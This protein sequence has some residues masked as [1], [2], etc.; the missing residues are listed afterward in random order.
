MTV[1]PTTTNT[2]QQ[3]QQH[4]QA[5]Q[6]H[7]C[8]ASLQPLLQPRAD[9]HLPHLQALRLAGAC[10]FSLGQPAQAAQ[11]F[12]QVTQRS[13]A[14]KGDAQDWL[15]L[16]SALDESKQWPEAEVAYQEALAR[17]PHLTQARLQVCALLRMLG[18]QEEAQ[19]E[20]QKALSALP[21]GAPATERALL[22]HALGVVAHALGGYAAA[23]PWM[24]QAL[25]LNPNLY[26][27][28]YHLAMSAL[29]HGDNVAGWQGFEWR[30]GLSQAHKSWR[31]FG[32]GPSAVAELAAQTW[33]TC[34]SAT[35]ATATPCASPALAPLWRGQA[36]GEASL[37]VWEE[38]GLGDTLQFFRYMA[39]LRAREPKATL[40]FW[41]RATLHPVLAAWAQQQGVKL[42]PAESLK[43]E[44]VRGQEW[45]VPLLSLPFCLRER[46]YPPVADTLQAPQDRLPVWQERM[47][48]YPRVRHVGLV[49]SGTQVQT[50]STRR[51]LTLQQLAPWLSV[52]HVQWHSLQVGARAGDVALSQW[53][54]HVVDWSHHLTDFGETAALIE[55]LDLVI[56]VD[57]ST[58]HLA[59][60]LGKPTWV[61]SRYDACWRWLMGRD[62]SPWYAS[63]RVFRQPQPFDW[64]D[65]VER[66]RWHLLETEHRT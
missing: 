51:N 54:G 52:P 5:G 25:A 66:V 37:L 6:Y 42:L 65:V 35:T 36:L 39:L 57:T 40:L 48:R 50:M 15:N 28:R 30:W 55:Q 9:G 41:C 2:L 60:S 38:Q 11:M 53:Q 61:L 26:E 22:L 10:L 27:G 64:A 44:H 45:H 18:R 46:G 24:T 47:A 4:Y 17:Q 62:D 3:A 8:L 29:A 13:P 16:A 58:A 43:P 63:V 1:M 14:G 19:I 59:A 23:E 7:A 33:E 34:P 49:W 31:A 12:E 56:T 20:L 32:E 21:D